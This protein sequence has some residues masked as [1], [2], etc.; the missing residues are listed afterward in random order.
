MFFLNSSYQHLSI[1][2]STRRSSVGLLA[3]A[4]L[5]II[6]SKVTDAQSQ[7]DATFNSIGTSPKGI[8]GEQHAEKPDSDTL[9]FAMDT[10]SFAE[11]TQ[12]I[13]NEKDVEIHEGSIK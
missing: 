1:D 12:L 8:P 7:K 10:M 5:P 4:P 11:R 2:C 3:S 9:D 13:R 6:E